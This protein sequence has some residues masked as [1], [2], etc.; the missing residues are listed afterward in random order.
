MNRKVLL[1]A[2]LLLALFGLEPRPAAAPVASE[3]QLSAV[4]AHMHEHLAQISAIKSA[5]ISGRLV[6]AR[7]PATWL[8]EHETATGLPAEFE[9]YVSEMRSHALQVLVAPDLASAAESVSHMAKTCG[10]CHLVNSV[11]VQFGYDRRP[12]EDLEDVIAHM[13]RHQWATDR[14]WEGL[15]GPSDA[16]WN[17]GT[18]MLIDAP[19][20]PSDVATAT[21]DAAAISRIARRIHALGGI[22]TETSTPDERSTLYAEVLGLCAGCHTLLNSGPGN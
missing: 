16:A 10:N 12:R 11:S 4:A 5:I 3:A 15:I 14:L 7:E 19:L 9:K 13:Q 6:D 20:L 1:A 18:D 17:K 21:E 2:L 22:G 8:A